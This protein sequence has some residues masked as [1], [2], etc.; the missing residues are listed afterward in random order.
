[1]K[2]E[3]CFRRNSFVR[4]ASISSQRE[5]QCPPSPPTFGKSVSVV[6]ML[7][8]LWSV[9]WIWL[10]THTSHTQILHTRV[11]RGPSS[12]SHIP[13]TLTPQALWLPHTASQVPRF[14]DSWFQVRG[15]RELELYSLFR[16]AVPERRAHC[17]RGCENSIRGGEVAIQRQAN[18]TLPDHLGRL[19]VPRVPPESPDST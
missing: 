14:P 3:S 17:N 16:E 13:R 12:Q 15:L 2:A 19:S 11:Q 1:M 10:H 4:T 5:S 8:I 18:S 6:V 7:R 9:T